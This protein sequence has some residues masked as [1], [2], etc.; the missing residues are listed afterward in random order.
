MRSVAIVGGSL[1]GLRTAETLRKDGFDGVIHFI[2]AEPHQPY[3]RPP[4]SKELLSGK[5][6]AENVWLSSPENFA[7]LKLEQHLG[8]AAVG[9]DAASKTVRLESGQELTVDGVC[10]A[11]GARPRML[12]GQT[13]SLKGVYTLR[14]LEDSLALKAEFDASTEANPKKLVV[15]GAGFIGAEVAATAKE[16]GLEVT[17]VE[18]L[19]VPLSRVLGETM[20]Q[21]LAELHQEHG[22]KLR[23]GVGV[24][25][26]ADASGQVSAVRL[27]DG[28]EI[29]ADVVV[30]GIGVLPNT[31]WLDG[32]GLQLDN[33]IVC[34]E[35]LLAAPGVTAA[36]DVARWPNRRFSGELMR[37]E[38]WDNAIEQGIAAARRLM[39]GDSG[40]AKPFEPV[41]WFWSDQFDRK[42]QLAGV[43]SPQG[44]ME[45]VAGSLAERRFAALYERDGKVCGVLGM[46][47]P[48]LVMKLRQLV[49]DQVPWADGLE[50]AAGI[51]NPQ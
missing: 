46:N 14:T 16:R 12:P 6:A 28:S 20:G 21:V 29:P 8:T 11:T 47:N 40:Q 19:E 51:V 48:R 44:Q 1:A 33:G 5:L 49:A 31:E 2:S 35:T 15:V 39:A 50:A 7:E 9:F 27:S 42:I 34:D 43:P 32:S 41:P 45:V 22:V 4:L 24:A 13:S 17:M 10:L 30:V 38:H 25:K 37:V 23:L 36:G 3:D 18:M 26:L